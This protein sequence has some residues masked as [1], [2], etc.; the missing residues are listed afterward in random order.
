MVHGT[1]YGIQYEIHLTKEIDFYNDLLPIWMDVRSRIEMEKDKHTGNYKLIII[2]HREFEKQ[3]LNS[4]IFKSYIRENNSI[5]FD[6]LNRSD[7]EIRQLKYVMV[8]LYEKIIKNNTD[9]PEPITKEK[10]NKLVM[11]WNEIERNSWMHDE[12]TDDEWR[13][14]NIKQFNICKQLKTQRIIHDLEYFDEIKSLYKE[15]LEQVSFTEEQSKI[16]EK[17]ISHPKLDSIISR[18]GLTLVD[19]IL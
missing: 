16:I 13:E 9:L 11:E 7:D 4:S 8:N 18:H 5:A 6:K 19:G 15:L 12:M 14:Y 17:V 10:Y 3:L 2:S 1:Y